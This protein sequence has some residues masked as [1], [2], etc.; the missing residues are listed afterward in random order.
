M[1]HVPGF[2]PLEIFH[3]SLKA[4]CRVI[5][6]I[7]HNNSPKTIITKRT[8]L[9]GR[10]WKINEKASGLA[11]LG[12]DNSYV[13]SLSHSLA[14]LVGWL[15][16]FRIN[17]QALNLVEQVQQAGGQSW[18]RNRNSF[19]QL[20]FGG[21]E[22]EKQRLSTCPNWATAAAILLFKCLNLAYW[23]RF[24]RTEKWAW[25]LVNFFC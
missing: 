11:W 8:Q 20:P 3:T 12:L 4:N 24:A 9:A 15:V 21:C 2:S 19:L 18:S 6:L 14:W 5:K 17:L 16:H 7:D 23:C 13:H 25:H 1:N 10:K 22:I